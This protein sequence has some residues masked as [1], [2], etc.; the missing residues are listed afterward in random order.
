[1]TGNYHPGQR[2]EEYLY[3]KSP[4]VLFP[5]TNPSSSKVTTIMTSNI[6]T[7]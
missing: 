7:N 4:L 2:L 5:I 6:P 1:M 3:P